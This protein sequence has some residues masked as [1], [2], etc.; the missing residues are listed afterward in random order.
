LSRASSPWL[1]CALLF[2]CGLSSSPS[3]AQDAPD[4]LLEL[5]PTPNAPVSDDAVPD[6]VTTPPAPPDAD[7]EAPKEAPAAP[8]DV[9][10]KAGVEIPAS[11]YVVMQI[12]SGLIYLAIAGVAAGYLNV[13][14]AIPVV[15]QLLV[16]VT[17]FLAPGAVVAWAGN[18]L[19]KKR[20]G[21]LFP[22]L[23]SCATFAACSLVN[24]AMLAGL[25]VV[26]FAGFYVGALVA[27]YGLLLQNLVVAGVGAGALVGGLLLLPTSM[28]GFIGAQLLTIVGGNAA[29]AGVH[30][31]T[32]PKNAGS[33]WELPPLIGR[34]ASP[35]AGESDARFS[36]AL[37]PMA[38]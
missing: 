8:K 12:A 17:F 32:A 33:R 7:M 10:Q 29:A 1:L 26:G 4:A 14:F 18:I 28:G 22:A 11:M 2:G 19:F 31:L 36:S 6:E 3:L 21:V 35:E 15:G 38:F 24:V 34:P 20:G 25:V 30:H 23:A 27:M 9:E 37:A 16:L 5:A 13:I